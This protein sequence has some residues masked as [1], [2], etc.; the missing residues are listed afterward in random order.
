MFFGDEANVFSKRAY[1]IV[2]KLTFIAIEHIL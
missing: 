2:V 1:V